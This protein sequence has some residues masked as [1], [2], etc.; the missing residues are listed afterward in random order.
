M[1]LFSVAVHL[2]GA[3]LEILLHLLWVPYEGGLCC[4]ALPSASLP[5]EL[6][7]EG[8]PEGRRALL[9][10]VAEVEGEAGQLGQLV[11]S[12]KL[13]WQST[14]GYLSMGVTFRT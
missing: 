4:A 2:H 14:E 7:D 9:L 10:L 1:L 12:E 6:L 3:A 13:G 8:M 11:G 5:V